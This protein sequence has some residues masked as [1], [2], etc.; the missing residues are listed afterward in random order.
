M[1]MASHN[2]NMTDLGSFLSSEGAEFVSLAYRFFLHR[3]ADAG[4]LDFYVKKLQ[5]GSPKLQI[6]ADIRFSEECINNKSTFRDFDMILMNHG[7]YNPSIKSFDDTTVNSSSDGGNNVSPDIRVDL[8]RSGIKIFL[9]GNCQMEVIASYLSSMLEQV[10]VKSLLSIPRNIDLVSKSEF[11]CYLN[12]CDLIVLHPQNEI[13]ELF[14][15]KYARYLPKIRRIPRIA[16]AGFHP[17]SE[18]VFNK[19]TGNFVG[20][21][22][23]DYNSTIALYGWLNSMSVEDTVGLFR[24]D[25]Y[26]HLGFYEYWDAAR[27]IVLEEGRVTGFDL[28]PYLEKWGQDGIWMYSMNHPVKFVLRDIALALVGR[29]GGQPKDFDESSIVDILQYGP[30]FPVFPEIASKVNVEGD[31]QFK[32]PNFGKSGDADGDSARKL[33]LMEY[34]KNT[35]DIYGNYEKENLICHR[36]DSER[37]KSLNTVISKRGKDRAGLVKLSTEKNPYQGLNDYQFWRRAIENTSM[38]NV[39]PVVRSC[40]VLKKSD[41]VATAGSCFAQHISRTLQ[42]NGFNY[43]VTEN[44]PYAND[45]DLDRNYGVFSARYG[46]VYTARQLVQ[47]FDRAYDAFTPLDSYWVRTDGR[48]ADPFRPQIEPK[49]FSSVVELIES[50]ESHFSAVRTMFESLDVIVF[51]LGLTEAWR[52]KADGAVFPLAPGVAAGCFDADLYEYINFGVIDVIA[53]MYAFIERLQKVNPGARMII[54]VS[55]VPLIATYEDRHVLVSTTYSKSVLRVAAEEI[56][57]GNPMA[58]Y[59]P[60]YE[61]ITGA[62]VKGEYYEND[63]RSVKPQGVDHVMRLFMKY[64]SEGGDKFEVHNVHNSRID[65]LKEMTKASAIVCDEEAIEKSIV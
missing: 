28:A 7:F 51:T 46:N 62:H 61:I 5:S 57:R 21:A 10:E 39:D 23:G 53:D 12:E 38:Q 26:K 18:Y 54:T 24:D 59:F 22:I 45:A 13:D 37:Y 55:P 52:R 14:S 48:F 35:F 34:V 9:L 19:N 17:D 8:S 49:G 3:E 25:I 40:F 41:K 33:S 47:L 58:E 15:G 32:L 4:G 2:M 36:L 16:F 43:Y 42:K 60:S 65:I 30:W 31:Y 44:S 29:E 56:C 50:R 11:E 63:L 6:I 64:Y 27:Q 1:Y 20:S